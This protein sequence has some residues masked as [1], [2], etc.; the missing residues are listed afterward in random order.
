ME[1][2]VSV[3]SEP[4][5]SVTDPVRDLSR[6]VFVLGGEYLMMFVSLFM[7]NIKQLWYMQ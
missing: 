6:D 5:S 3:L 7:N 1:S 4:F 2:R